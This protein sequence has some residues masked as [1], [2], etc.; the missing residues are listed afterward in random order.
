M[1]EKKRTVTLRKA[2][3]VGFLSLILAAGLLSGCNF[4]KKGGPPHPVLL[5]VNLNEAIILFTFQRLPQTYSGLVRLND[6]IILI[7][8]ELGR[9]QEVEAQFPR[10]K[11]IISSERSNWV[12]VQR[13]LYAAVAKLE[14]VIEKI[15]VTHL[16]NADRGKELIEQNAQSLRAEVKEALDASVPHTGRLKTAVPNKN[17]LSR[18]KEKFFS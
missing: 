17:T 9:L 6:E 12:R 2:L 5:K 8:K 15:Y 18:L 11:T 1:A 14:K 10:Q 13:G 7:D 16:V 4:R 3:T